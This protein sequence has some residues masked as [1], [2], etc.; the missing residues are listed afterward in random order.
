MVGTFNGWLV[1]YRGVNALIATL[2]TATLVAGLV[3][4]VHE[5]TRCQRGHP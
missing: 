4:L 5:T 3:S 2:G 1:A